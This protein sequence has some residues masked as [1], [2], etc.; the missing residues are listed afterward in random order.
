MLH[1]IEEDKLVPIPF[2]SKKWEYEIT[3]GTRSQHIYLWVRDTE[4]GNARWCIDQYEDINGQVKWRV[5]HKTTGWNIPFNGYKGFA[6]INDALT[7]MWNYQIL[8][9][10]IDNVTGDLP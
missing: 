2:G 7:A 6:S 8:V 5:E 1:D 3:K 9:F 4:E 10:G